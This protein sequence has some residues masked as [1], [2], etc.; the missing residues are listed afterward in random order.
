MAHGR[1]KDLVAAKF[2]GRIFG[3]RDFIKKVLQQ[4]WQQA[5]ISQPTVESLLGAV[6]RHYKLTPA[7]LASLGKQRRSSVARGVLAY[8]IKQT[9]TIS[10]TELAKRV[11]RDAT[12]L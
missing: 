12:T 7:D 9:P 4:E 3:D 11:N 2:S 10:F 5:T 8:L 6:T 1:P